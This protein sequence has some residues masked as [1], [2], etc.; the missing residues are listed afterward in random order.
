M[1][2]PESK[3]RRQRR[4]RKEWLTAGLCTDCGGTRSEGDGHLCST[5]TGKRTAQQVVNRKKASKSRA[6]IARQLAS[7]YPPDE[8]EGK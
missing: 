7:Y 3:L 5:C 2:R 6:E 8:R 1:P 4:M